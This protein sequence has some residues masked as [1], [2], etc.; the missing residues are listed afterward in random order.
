MLAA[1]SSG[2]AGAGVETQPACRSSTRKLKNT[3]QP[4][5]SITSRQS[6]F[7]TACGFSEL[8]RRLAVRDSSASLCWARRVAVTSRNTRTTPLVSP[9]APRIGAALSSINSRAPLRETRAVWFASATMVPACSTFATGSSA[10]A[11]VLSSTIRNTSPSGRPS[12]SACGHPV[13]CSATPFS[14]I[15]RAAVSVAITASPML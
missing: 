2:I 10:G 7:T 13:S 1:T 14:I 12:A 11:P 3:W 8:S 5:C 9:A 6:A 15:T 4:R